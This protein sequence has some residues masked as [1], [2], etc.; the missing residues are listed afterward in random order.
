MEPSEFTTVVEES[1]FDVV[2]DA[3]GNVSSVL[4][5]NL[6]G[7]SAFADEWL[8]IYNEWRPLLIQFRY[9]S[10][11]GSASTGALVAYNER[12]VTDTPATTLAAAYREQESQEFRPWDDYTTS[13]KLTTLQWKPREPSDLEFYAFNTAYTSQLV[14]VGEDLP[15]STT[16][17]TMQIVSRLQFRG[18]QNPAPG[19]KTARAKR[20][21]Q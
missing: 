3:S 5:L 4:N 11:S 17:G 19:P 18:R 14:I 8:Q 12:D 10:R 2:S 21:K 9:H 7:L 15:V 16:V 6:L 13:P 1:S 20:T